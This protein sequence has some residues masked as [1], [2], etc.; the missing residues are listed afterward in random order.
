MCSHLNAG[1]G[2]EI[3]IGDLA[4]KVSKTIGYA[5]KIIFD[6]E[7][8]D[9]APRKLVDSSLI[10]GFGWKPTVALEKGLELTY[11]EVINCL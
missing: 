1:S 8:P 6:P 4:G 3:T 9:G 7:K 2:E 5:G 10:R 11:K